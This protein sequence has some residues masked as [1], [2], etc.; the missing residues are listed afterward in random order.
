MTRFTDALSAYG[1]GRCLAND[2]TLWIGLDGS[3]DTPNA[4]RVL[5]PPTARERV[6]FL[7]APLQA[8]L[9]AAFVA[10]DEA[11]AVRDLFIGT[12]Q[13]Y[14]GAPHFAD[15]DMAAAVA[16]LDGANLPA[17]T[18][19]TLGDMEDRSGGLRMFGT[20]GEIDHI[21]AAAPNLD[22]LGLHGNFALAAP[23][24]HRRLRVLETQFDDCG[25]TG[26]PIEQATLDHLLA[27]DFPALT[28]L[29]LDMDEGGGDETLT[30]PEALFTPGR[31]PALTTLG[32]D[33]LVP[34]DEAR[35]IAWREENGI[36]DPQG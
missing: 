18:A 22:T 9:V 35:L 25:V 2:T 29:D 27:S 32:I 21:F 34:E 33:R 15:F 30:L 31:F 10:S 23:V 36:A 19:L 5:A 17:L 4:R 11:A 3:S 1:L 16:A 26:E 28:Y 14:R 24:Q 20:I 12:S 7:E 13:D 6:V 8:E